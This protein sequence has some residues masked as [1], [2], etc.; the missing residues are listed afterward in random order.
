VE[1]MCD[2]VNEW[3][4]RSAI[5]LASYVMW[6]VNWIHPFHGG[7]GRTSRAVSYL[8]LCA[9]LGYRLPGTLAIPE[10]IVANRQPYYEALDAA[11]AAWATGQVN[12]EDMERLIERMLA[13]Q[14]A[15]VLKE[16]RKSSSLPPIV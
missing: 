10:Q 9:K 5:H 1:E 3:S 8:T 7:N 14:L 2:Y 13:V 11:D 12:V 6:R 15:S 16:A 4:Q